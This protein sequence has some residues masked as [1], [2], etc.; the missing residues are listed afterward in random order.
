MSS[1]DGWN[2]AIKR[3]RLE[4]GLNQGQAAD[5]AGLS[6]AQLSRY[7]AGLVHP[8]LRILGKLL[9]TYGADLKSFAARAAIESETPSCCSCQ[10]E[11][12]FFTF[13]ESLPTQWVN[14]LLD[15]VRAETRAT[16]AETLNSWLTSVSDGTTSEPLVFEFDHPSPG[17]GEYIRR[18]A[19]SPIDAHTCPLD[20]PFGKF[21]TLMK[22]AGSYSGGQKGKK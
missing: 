10:T 1:I 12:S 8:S 9:D 15:R 21:T 3:L 6:A 17:T 19:V 22:P 16:I 4:A 14:S 20:S 11:T 18:V 13:T 5:L 2:L 7:E